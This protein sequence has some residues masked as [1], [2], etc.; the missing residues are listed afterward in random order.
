MKPKYRQ[1]TAFGC[2]IGMESRRPMEKM[3]AWIAAYLQHLADDR[4][5]SVQTRLCY[6][7]DLQH[8]ANVM[9]QQGVTSPKELTQ[10]Q[11]QAYLRQLRQEGRSAATAMRRLA[12]IRGLCRFGMQDR[13]LEKDPT[14]AVDVPKPQR[15]P[16]RTLRTEEVE[17]L[18]GSPDVQS[19]IGMRDAAI[20]ELMYASGIRV[21]EL[22]AL[23]VEDLHP[24]LGLLRCVGSGGR[25]R[26]V[27][28]GS[29]AVRTLQRYLAE[30]RPALLK[31]DKPSAALFPNHFGMRLTR[32]GCWKMIKKYALSAGISQTLT[33]QMLR[34]SFAVHLL[35]NGA[36]V[37][38]VQEM[39]GHLHLQSTNLYRGDSRLK[40]KEEYDRT[41]PRAR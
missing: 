6:G 11:I 12:A 25:E 30:G 23:D 40:V 21:S 7:A 26:F 24:E 39:L 41:H 35:E 37:R 2:F 10:T 4:A 13:W 9:R 31:P 28:I 3:Q 15:K 1:A 38:A 8:F 32:Q 19:P 29:V 20:L 22:I 36:D 18:L 16:P 27:P 5:V 34:H 33:P 14:W 17:K